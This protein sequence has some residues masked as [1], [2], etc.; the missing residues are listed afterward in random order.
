[1]LPATHVVACLAGNG[2]GP[3]VVAEASRALAAV[4]R[5]H[6]FRIEERHPPFGAEALFRSGSHL[7]A[8]TRDAVLGAD[9]VLVAGLRAPALDGVRAELDLQA[10]VSRVRSAATGADVT[11]F[12]PLADAQPDFAIDRALLAAC[13]RRGRL[14]SVGVDRDWR[15]RVDARA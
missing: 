3:E 2:I 4:A 13:A 10:R 14:Q 8:S 11:V 7:P 12:A 9:A 1:M 5:L 15:A 6:G